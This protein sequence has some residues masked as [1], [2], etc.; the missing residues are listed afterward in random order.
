VQELWKVVILAVVQGV[1]EFLPISSDGHLVI[2]SLLLGVSLENDPKLHDL[3][4]VLHF[5]TLLSIVVIYFDRLLRLLSID[6][7]LI[8]PLVI[9]SIP[10]GVVGI[11]IKKGIP[12]DLANIILLNPFVT[13]VGFIVTG[14]A[15]LS[16]GS[17]KRGEREHNSIKWHEAFFI[18]CAQALAILPGVSRSGMTISTGLRLGLTP[19]SSATFS[20]LLGVPVIFGATL[21]GAIDSLRPQPVIL[22]SPDAIARMSPLS[23][24][25]GVVVSFAVG[26][27]SLRLLIGILERG[28]FQWFAWWCIPMG[29]GLFLYALL[30]PA[31]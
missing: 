21:L 25:I 2:A 8:W 11:V 24:L 7:Q 5:G 26:V 28:K 10:A 29:V 23:L 15:L 19:K 14:A 1:T 30:F 27:I 17:A 20:F 12:D 4:V 16:G 3:F 18:G 31:A 9:G 13:S 22:G 6:R